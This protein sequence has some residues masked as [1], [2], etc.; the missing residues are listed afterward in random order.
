[1]IQEQVRETAQVLASITEQKQDT[2]EKI[3][4]YH[5]HHVPSQDR[6]D[7]LQD[8]A[9]ALLTRRPNTPEL[10]FLIAKDKIA[11]FWRDYKGHRQYVTEE[12]YGGEEIQ[13]EE[14]NTISRIDTLAGE[15][16][17]E[18]RIADRYDSNTL[19]AQLPWNI[20]KAVARKLIGLPL[21][22][23]NRKAM[24]RYLLAKRVVHTEGGAK[25]ISIE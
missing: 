11:K 22:A 9:E 13:D 25:I 10:A 8:L 18:H 6:E 2:L 12:T 14:G 5:L 7:V 4:S 15:I 16:E 1:M 17:F 20:K 3:L 21:T 19:F 23:C 24:Q